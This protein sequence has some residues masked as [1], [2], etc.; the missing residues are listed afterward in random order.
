MVTLIIIAILVRI[1]MK[2]GEIRYCVLSHLDSKIQ[3]KI[4][5]SIE[6]KL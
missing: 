1:F 3:T 4:D 2:D 5:K 6:E